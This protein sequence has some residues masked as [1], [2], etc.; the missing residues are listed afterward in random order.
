MDLKRI[1]EKTDT[2]AGRWFDNAVLALI[3]ISLVTFSFETL[4]DLS[5]DAAS[6]LRW[7]ELV[8]VLLFTAEY[9]LRIA[10]ADHRWRFARSFFGLVDLAAI[11]PFYLSLGAIDLRSVRVFRLLRLLRILKLAR[12]GR[13][14]RRLHRAVVLMRE[15]LIL[16]LNVALILIYLAAVGIYYFERDSQPEQFASVF[17]SLWWAFVTLTTVGYG[18][19]YPITLGGRIFTAVVLF[20]GLGLVAAPTGLFAS[21]LA[22]ARKEE[23]E[24]RG[25]DV[26]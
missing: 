25:E 15:E 3:I 9:I 20:V 13:V 7:V 4:P 19:V 16:F 1:V 8:T 21:A 23:E 6:I 2:P 24:R 10:V 12:Y 17:H 18:D 26:T 5:P 14:V 22:Q 11:L